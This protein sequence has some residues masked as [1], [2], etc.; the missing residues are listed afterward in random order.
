MGFRKVSDFDGGL[1][2]W[3]R[4]GFSVETGEADAS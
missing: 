2:A 1:Y 3:E 4:A